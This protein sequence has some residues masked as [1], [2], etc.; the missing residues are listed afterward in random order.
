MIIP[1]FDK[2]IIQGNGERY[3]ENDLEN[4]IDGWKIIKLI[5]K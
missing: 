1:I 4:K 3:L 5:I 2:E